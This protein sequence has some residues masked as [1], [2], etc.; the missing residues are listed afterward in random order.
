MKKHVSYPCFSSCTRW[1]FCC[2]MVAITPSALQTIVS[3]VLTSHPGRGH[4]RRSSWW[5]AWR[6]HTRWR[7]SP[8]HH[9]WWHPRRRHATYKQQEGN[10][11]GWDERRYALYLLTEKSQMYSLYSISCLQYKIL[12]MY[13]MWHFH[14]HTHTHKHTHHGEGA[15]VEDRQQVGGYKSGAWQQ[16]QCQSAGPSSE[17]MAPLHHVL[18]L[19][20]LTCGEK[21]ASPTKMTKHRKGSTSPSLS[22]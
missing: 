17:G 6:R 19:S 21:N 18:D 3:C 20:D 13:N 4:P 1:Q 16:L 14:I 15:G 22:S 2:F 9:V 10:L 11:Q 7:H 12:C 5:H 8:A